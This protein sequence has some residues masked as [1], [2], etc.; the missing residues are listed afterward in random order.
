MGFLFALTITGTIN[1]QNRATDVKNSTTDIPT[2][3]KKEGFKD[4]IEI[5]SSGM[6]ASN[7]SKTVVV[8]GGRGTL[9]F[10]NNDDKISNVVYI[11]PAG[12]R[13]NLLPSKPG[14]NGAP[15]PSCKYPLPDACFA[16]SDKS[17]GMCMCKPTDLTSNTD[18]YTIGLLLPAVQSVRQPARVN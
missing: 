3:A 16:T 13:F 2:S 11:D 12:K 7:G 6:G 14:T 9:Q 18:G 1:A 15:Q 17:I 4:W 5:P 8:P 10:T